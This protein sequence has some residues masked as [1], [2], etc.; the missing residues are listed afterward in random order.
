MNFGFNNNAFVKYAAVVVSVALCMVSSVEAKQELHDGYYPIY[1]LTVA[2]NNISED[3]IKRG[4]YLSKMGDCIACHTNTEEGTPVFAG[5]LPIATPF[6]TFYTPNITPDLKTGIGKWSEQDFIRSLKHGLSPEGRNYFPVFPFVYFSNLTDEDASDLYAYFMSIPAV[7]KVNKSL[8]F[9]FNVPGARLSLWGWKLLFFFPNEKIVEDA[10]KSPEWNRGNY[11]VNGLGH[12]SLC[13]TP[14]SPL[15]API[16]RYFLT[17]G[18]ID[19]YW[20]PNI[21]KRA[22]DGIDDED[23]IK[24]FTEGR[25]L[26]NAGPVAGP[27][28]EVNHNSLMY[29]THD[30]LKSI[31]VYLKTVESEERLG[32][33]GSD[34]K[35]SLQR[36]R[37]VYVSSCIECHQKGE[38]GAPRIGNGDSF[39]QRL[40][41]AGGIKALY[42]NAIKGFNSMPLKGAC[43]TC[44]DNDIISAVD[45][46]LD[47]SLTRSQRI[48]Q[49]LQSYS[50]KSFELNNKRAENVTAK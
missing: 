19:G 8:P 32:V 24:V 26:N 22:L 30:D 13:H 4:E 33:P 36:G 38:M 17:G 42:R 20:A 1:P 40:Q 5:G 31:G 18:F 7:E 21:T 14:L 43:L 44:T 37:Q 49:H 50:A 45:Y 11:I 29:L 39:A 2:K 25:L 6:G 46:L 23:V 34:A 9:P 35:P 48:N 16:Q 27:M 41:D 12:C 10:T 47:Q 3:K 28:A 15:G